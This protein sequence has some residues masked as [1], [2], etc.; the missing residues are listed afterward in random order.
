MSVISK[1]ISKKFLVIILL[2]L[3]VS[4]M[5]LFGIS[6]I[7]Y[8]N[9]DILVKVGNLNVAKD[10]FDRA[11]AS[12]VNYL[13]NL[14]QNTLT[15]NEIEKLGV[16]DNVLNSMIEELLIYNFSRKMSLYMNDGPAIDYIRK[17]KIFMDSNGL[18]DQDKFRSY[19]NMLNTTESKYLSD[20]KRNIILNIFVDIFYSQAYPSALYSDLLYKEKFKT[21]NVDLLVLHPDIVSTKNLQP[22]EDEISNYY[23][24]NNSRFYKPEYRKIEYVMFNTDNVKHEVS[25]S[26]EEF[27]EYLNKRL[28]NEKKKERRDFDN[29]LFPD[30]EKA[31]QFC[32]KVIDSGNFDKTK[33]EFS[34]SIISSNNITKVDSASL[35]DSISNI[36][37]S[38][39]KV[40]QIS[41]PFNTDLG[42]HVIKLTNIYSLSKDDI[43]DEVRKDLLDYKSR[44]FLDNLI[45]EFDKELSNDSAQAVVSL[46]ELTKKYNLKVKFSGYSSEDGYDQNNVFIL[47]NDNLLDEFLLKKIFNSE[48]GIQSEVIQNNNKDSY[49]TFK[50]IDIIPKTL[51]S[52][53]QVKDEITKILINK[54]RANIL[55]KIAMNVYKELIDNNNNIDYIKKVAKKHNTKFMP[56]ETLYKSSTASG[57]GIDQNYSTDLVNKIF[58]SDVGTV[59][60]P[61]EYEED[62]FVLAIVRSFEPAKDDDN[63]MYKNKIN[64]MLNDDNKFDVYSQFMDYLKKH[65]KIKYTELK[66]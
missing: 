5:G 12:E 48:L 57:F 7:I 22:S 41:R 36:V 2:V 33:E 60:G 9:R 23:N 11:L 18:F 8:N 13:E 37:F 34:K 47:G 53:T 49:I 32:E 16:K 15:A 19:L 30:Y 4:G 35:P 55:K 59:V 65:N 10:D 1:V 21:A 63:S 44:Q 29:L 24:N 52:L 38:L 46:R 54:N 58:V 25:I 31:K 6:E 3:T 45:S 56:H 64:R 66:L 43:T 42:W 28:E 17:G 62:K 39:D 27:Q 40:G 26:D 20:L 61:I 51:K 50:V 14:F